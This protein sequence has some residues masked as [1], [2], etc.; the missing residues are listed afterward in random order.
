MPAWK[1]RAFW[2][3][4]FK[5]KQRHS[6]FDLGYDPCVQQRD[7]LSKWHFSSVSWSD[8]RLITAASLPNVFFNHIIPSSVWGSQSIP[9]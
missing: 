7:L 4:R 3:E 5:Q 6:S 8:L 2:S 9:R 1:L